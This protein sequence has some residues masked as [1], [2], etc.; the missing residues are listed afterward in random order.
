MDNARH[1]QRPT[2]QY[3]T[4]QDSGE[5][6]APSDCRSC[7]ES[8]LLAPIPVATSRVMRSV[9]QVAP[10]AWRGAFLHRCSHHLPPVSRTITH[11]HASPPLS[12]P[13][14]ASCRCSCSA[15]LTGCYSITLAGESVMQARGRLASTSRMRGA[16][17]RD[18]MGDCSPAGQAHTTVRC[19]DDPRS[20]L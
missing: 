11:C 8:D 13:A 12:R 3:E 10:A 9:T 7:P 19:R 15:G 20:P 14:L 18:G 17:K 6:R 16:Y 2:G 4:E 5:G 1:A